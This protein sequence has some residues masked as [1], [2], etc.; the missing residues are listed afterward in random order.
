MLNQVMRSNTFYCLAA[1][2][3]WLCFYL[4]V[5]DT[6]VP[7]E[8][9]TMQTNAKPLDRGPPVVIALLLCLCIVLVVILYIGEEWLV[10]WWWWQW[11][12]YVCE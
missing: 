3:A 7:A 9:V 1:Q 11:F 4:V 12:V 2:S 8:A 10:L 5:F 6:I